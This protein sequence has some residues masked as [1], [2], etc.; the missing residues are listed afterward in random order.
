MCVLGWR[1]GLHSSHRFWDWSFLQREGHSQSSALLHRRGFGRW[2]ERMSIYLFQLFHLQHPHKFTITYAKA[3]AVCRM[4]SDWTSCIYLMFEEQ[5]ACDCLLAF[6]SSCLCLCGYSLTRRTLKKEKRRLVMQ[7]FKA[8][9][10]ISL[11]FAVEMSK[12]VYVCFRTLMRRGKRTMKEILTPQSVSRSEST[13]FSFGIFIDV[14]FE[15]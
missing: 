4:C 3:L 11:F 6:S 7:M 2:W 10:N 14:F 9:F 5:T 13:M 8:V 15:W 1:L 12:C